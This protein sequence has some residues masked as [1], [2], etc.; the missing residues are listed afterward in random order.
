WYAGMP[1][2]RPAGQVNEFASQFAQAGPPRPPAGFPPQPSNFPAGAP[3]PVAAD[4]APTD[5][6]IA[7]LGVWG[8]FWRGLLVTLGNLVVIP[9]PWTA[10]AIYRYFSQ[11]TW[12][13]DGRRLT[14]AGQA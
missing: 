9:A 1:D 6:L 12:L 11:N 14:F 4:G 13:P 5:R 7:Q 3:A 2:W 8:L 10:T